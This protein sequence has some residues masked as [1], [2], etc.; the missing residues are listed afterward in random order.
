MARLG[1]IAVAVAILM[2]M[3]GGAW[4]DVYMLSPRGCNNRLNEESVN[5]NN[6]N[7]M[8]DT[9][10][11][12]KGGYAWGPKMYYYAGSQLMVE[13]T[14]QH[15][16][17]PDSKQRNV[18]CELVLQYTCGDQ[19]RD[20][21]TT[22]SIPDDANTYNEKAADTLNNNGKQ[23]YKYGMHESYA[24]Y[25][26]C[27]TR[28]RNRGLFLADQKPGPAARNTRQNPNGG[29]SGFECPEERDYYPYWHPTPWKDI[30]VLTSDLSRCDYYKENSE[31]SRGRG[32]CS[33]PKL[34]NERQCVANNGTWMTAPSHGGDIDC[35]EAPLSRD[36]H[37]GNTPT[38]WASSYNWTIPNDPNEN[39]VLRLRYNISVGDYDGWNTYSDQNE[40]KT[41]GIK[42]P[43]K[44][45]PTV[46][47]E[48]EDTPV[49]KARNLTLALNTAQTGRT[50][51][52][53]SY[54]FSIRSRPSSI[55]PMDKIFNL[56]VRGKRGNIVQTYPCVEYDFVPTTLNVR[57]NDH[58]HVQWTGSI[59]NPKNNDGEGTY[60]VD[61]S[62]IVQVDSS[63]ENIPLS[64]SD[65]G[66]FFGE[67]ARMALAHL[68]QK[69]CET[70]AQLR[71]RLGDDQNAINRD[72]KNCAKL[73]AASTYQD[74]GLHKVGASQ[75]GVYMFISTRNN[76]FSNRSQKMTI[77]SVPF[78]PVWAIVLVV[79]AGTAC[80]A[81]IGLSW[82][83]LWVRYHPDSRAAGV[84]NRMSVN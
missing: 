2:M 50:F 12:G 68:N 41:K 70:L 32:Y 82:F 44:N 26:E 74:H 16:C 17:G 31:N 69:G 1:T 61:A 22:E 28:E 34:N 24:Y 73:N 56:N 49:I 48:T 65:P 3:V 25:Q 52:D 40:D 6:N 15:G 9:Q 81:S 59:Y 78:L 58:I 64:Y 54:T 38:G 55:G 18:H 62:N 63:D 76:N 23:A 60:G 71:A 72:P 19:I 35:R 83:A 5:R 14:N 66:H 77:I 36:N 10:N 67:D 20:G 42:S 79:L 27:K 45:N 57:P 46:Q 7:R 4:G 75:T 51:Q 47:F 43:I 8:C 39:C 37:L 13:W 29:R 11:N 30:A 33:N 84:W 80:L 21:L 53:R